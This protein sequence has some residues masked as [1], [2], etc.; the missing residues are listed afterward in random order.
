MAIILNQ[1]IRILRSFASG[2]V[3]RKLRWRK[4]CPRLDDGSDDAPLRLHLVATREECR[5]TS[6]R[7]EKKCLISDRRCRSERI[8]IGEIHVH[9]T[10]SH[11]RAGS[12]RP[13]VQ[14]DALIW[15]YPHRNHIVVDVL[16]TSRK[17]RLGCS[18]EMDSNLRYLL[19]QA[20]A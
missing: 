17:Q 14:R 8:T 5:V 4:L 6:H 12:L 20:L 16:W 15:L 7:V 11:M 2:S 19:G 9:T 10:G 3:I 18:L 1:R 13:E